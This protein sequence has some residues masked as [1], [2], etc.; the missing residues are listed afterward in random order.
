MAAVQV[1]TPV[2]LE[3]GPRSPKLKAAQMIAGRRRGVAR[4]TK[5]DEGR[6][7]PPPAIPSV[8]V[9]VEQ[10]DS[11]EIVRSLLTSSDTRSGY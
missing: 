6:K 4:P 3:S 10:E 11:Q 2:T 7:T 5:E 9:P 8:I 1:E